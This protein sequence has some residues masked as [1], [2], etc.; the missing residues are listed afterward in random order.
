M[1]IS[2]DRKGSAP[3][4][5]EMAI[6]WHDQSFSLSGRANQQFTVRPIQVTTRGQLETS[7]KWPTRE[8]RASG[9]RS[10]AASGRFGAKRHPSRFHTGADVPVG[11]GEE[12]LSPINGQVILL[13]RFKT[14]TTLFLKSEAK[15]D[16]IV[17][18]AHLMDSV[19]EVGQFVDQETPLGRAMNKAEFGKTRHTYNHIHLEARKNLDDWGTASI[20]TGAARMLHRR[21]DDPLKY[22]TPK[23]R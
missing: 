6:A 3:Q 5:L 21:F 13:S 7:W 19:V 16:L 1:S 2:Y 9:L 10:I 14:Q 12:I 20:D 4:A 22:L 23:K 11:Y 18:I 15:P 8:L 17:G